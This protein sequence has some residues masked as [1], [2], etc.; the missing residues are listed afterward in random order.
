MAIAGV[1]FV[2]NSTYPRIQ[3]THI[4]NQSIS[5]KQISFPCLQKNIRVIKT[6]DFDVKRNFIV[7]G[8]SK[9][10]EEAPLPSDE[11]G[12]RQPFNFLDACSRIWILE[13]VLKA[14]LPYLSTKCR[15]LLE[16]KVEMVE[17]Y[18]D[19]VEKIAEEIEKILKYI[20]K[21]LPGDGIPK[22]VMDF[23][24]ILAEE[25]AKTAQ[26]F[27]NFLDEVLKVEK[28]LESPSESPVDEN[29]VSSKETNYGE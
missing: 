5:F 29:S 1:S 20:I 16:A 22:K 2:G 6:L 15:N 27:K 4:S 28:Q 13:M 10:P 17:R 26:F 21:S 18:M 9:V 23:L 3:Q 8:S 11:S 7:C 12:Q 19:I 14:V 24:E 25:I